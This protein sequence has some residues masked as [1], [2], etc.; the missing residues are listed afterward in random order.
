MFH[1]RLGHTMDVRLRPKQPAVVSQLSAK[2]QVD[3]WTEHNANHSIIDGDGLKWQVR[4][5]YHEEVEEEEKK[6]LYWQAVVTVGADA[7]V[8]ELLSTGTLDESRDARL[9][10]LIGKRGIPLVLKPLVF[11]A[12]TSE[13]I[14]STVSEEVANFRRKLGASH[15]YEV[16]RKLIGR[17]VDEQRRFDKPCPF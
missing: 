17:W 8:K 12:S 3:D 9:I 15:L 11:R 16:K 10:G 5:S 2:V 14:R 6:T 1:E 4:I 13:G 7:G